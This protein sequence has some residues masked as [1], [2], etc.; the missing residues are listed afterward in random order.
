MTPS[1]LAEMHGKADAIARVNMRVRITQLENVL[2]QAREKLELYRAQHDGNYVGG[3]EYTE[4][5]RRIK[6]A[7]TV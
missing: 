7:L 6:A 5:M 4:L 3:V 2:L 1:E